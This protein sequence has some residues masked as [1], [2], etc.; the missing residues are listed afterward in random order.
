MT[1]DNYH[2]INYIDCKHIV[3]TDSDGYKYRIAA[4]NYAN[5]RR[6]QWLDKNPFA[7]ENIR[8]YLRLNYPDIAL[9]SAEYKGCKEPIEFICKK[10]SDKGVQRRSTNN[11]VHNRQGCHYCTIEKLHLSVDES[12]IRERCNELGVEFVGRYI[13]DKYDSVVNYICRVHKDKGIQHKKWYHLRTCAKSCPYCAGKKWT[14]Q[15]LRDAISLISPDTIIIGEYKGL[16]SKILCRCKKC[17]N[18]WETTP[19]SLKGGSGCPRCVQSHGERAISMYLD[20]NQI[21]YTTQKTFD[22]CVYEQKL[23]FDFFLP[24]INTTIEYDGQQHFFPVDFASRGKEWAEA[25]YEKNRIKDKIKT[26][27]CTDNG[28]TLIRIPYYDIGNID[29]ILA[30]ALAEVSCKRQV[31]MR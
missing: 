16:Y 29:N 19:A 27:Y 9:L 5:G 30:S 26:D 10:H 2:D 15:D 21:P 20:N 13:D 4:E 17:D 28:I 24:T 8:N 3:I 25:E 1:R 22:D 14:T 23:K 7:I 31:C 18:E 11:L 12:V 6:P